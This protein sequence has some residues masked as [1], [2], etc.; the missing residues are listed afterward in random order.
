VNLCLYFGFLC[1]RGNGVNFMKIEGRTSW[2]DLLFISI[3]P[4]MNARSSHS[5]IFVTNWDLERN[6]H[7]IRIDKDPGAYLLC[8]VF[9]LTWG[10]GQ[11]D[12]FSGYNFSAYDDGPQDPVAQCGRSVRLLRLLF[13]SY[14]LGALSILRSKAIVLLESCWS[15]FR[16]LF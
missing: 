1:V 11:V 13:S 2:H 8:Q 10:Y 6:E 14:S 4:K 16:G 9:I 3:Q 12:V 7:G 15:L 5:Q